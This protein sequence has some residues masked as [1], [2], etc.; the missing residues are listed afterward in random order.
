MTPGPRGWSVL[1]ALAALAFAF[2]ASG[3]GAHSPEE[4]AL[5]EQFYSTWMMPDAPWA[6]CCHN[7]DCHPAASRFVNG[8]WEARWAD[9]EQWSPIPP[10]KVEQNRESPDGRS[11]MCGRQVGTGVTVYCFVRGGGV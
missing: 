3:T 10:N 2:Y 6:S 5:H 11:H 7:R 9:T 1:F 4:M 8:H